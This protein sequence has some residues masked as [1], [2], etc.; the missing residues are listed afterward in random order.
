MY[1]PGPSDQN[2]GQEP[3][4]HQR[5]RTLQVVIERGI[6]Q[7]SQKTRQ[8]PQSPILFWSVTDGVQGSQ[9]F[10]EEQVK[11]YQ[12]KYDAGDPDLRRQLQISVVRVIPFGNKVVP[13]EVCPVQI[14]MDVVWS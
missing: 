2:A 10:S 11:E 13:N 3:E 7:K 4:K 12:E 6:D 1:L 5:R 8:D 14:S 9:N